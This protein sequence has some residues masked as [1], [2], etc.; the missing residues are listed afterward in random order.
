MNKIMTT[1][2]LIKR[3]IYFLYQP[4]NITVPQNVIAL[5]SEVNLYRVWVA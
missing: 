1:V 5:Y 2:R 3:L 4:V